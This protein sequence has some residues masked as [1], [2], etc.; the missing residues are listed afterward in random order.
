MSQVNKLGLGWIALYNRDTG[1]AFPQMHVKLSCHE[2]KW[3]SKCA[4]CQD[5]FTGNNELGRHT[6]T[7][8]CL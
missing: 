7:G 2:N 5:M 4:Y 1:H 3:H 6:H 8:L